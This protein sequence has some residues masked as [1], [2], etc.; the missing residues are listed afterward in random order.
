MR[1]TIYKTFFNFSS[2]LRT[3]Y[4]YIFD[5]GLV[6]SQRKIAYLNRI[7]PKKS[8]KGM[9]EDMEIW[10]PQF[11]FHLRQQLVTRRPAMRFEYLNADKLFVDLA[12]TIM[13]HMKR[14]PCDLL[15]IR[16]YLST[17]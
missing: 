17:R 3:S 7:N 1:N 8:K 5:S 13:L 2:Q 12:G 4:L 6:E 11:C 14:G 9:A 15:L 10:S 16:N